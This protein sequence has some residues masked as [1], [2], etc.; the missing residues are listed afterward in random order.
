M[1]LVRILLS[2]DIRLC[3]WKECQKMMAN[4]AAFLDSFRNFD[5]SGV[6]MRMIRAC[7]KVIR[8]DGLSESELVGKSMAVAALF[9]WVNAYVS[10]ARSNP[11]QQVE[12][13]N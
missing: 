10:R 12:P 13:D 1:S 6:T 2:G 5:A 11:V 4:P 8:A 7:Q 3:S 9:N